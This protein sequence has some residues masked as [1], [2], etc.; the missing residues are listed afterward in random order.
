[1]LMK[2]LIIIIIIFLLIGTFIIYTENKINIEKKQD[3]AEFFSTF[4]AWIFQIG[5]NVMDLTG[6]AI[7]QKWL[8]ANLTNK[9]KVYIIYEKK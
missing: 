6:H 3:R 8:P 5:G 7:Q 4:S 9:T 1:M 2:I